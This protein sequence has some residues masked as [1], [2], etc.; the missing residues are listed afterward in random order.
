[1]A[2]EFR[3]LFDG[4]LPSLGYGIVDWIEANLRHP[5]IPGH[6]LI[7]LTPEQTNFIIL[8]YALHPR[9]GR[10]LIRRATH[11]ASKGCGKAWESAGLAYATLCGP[12]L[13]DGWD[14]NGQPVGRPRIN[15][16]IFI[17]APS[18]DAT[19]NVYSQIVGI[20]EVSDELV[21]EN[22]LH[23]GQLK[24][25]DDAN[26]LIQPVAVS[27]GAREGA[28][29]HLVL[30]DETQHF[31]L[32]RHHNVAAT[33]ARNVAKSGGLVVAT[34]NAYQIGQGSLAEDEAKVAED[35]DT[36]GVLYI[37]EAPD[38]V[39]YDPKDPE[40]RDQLLRDLRIC[41]GGALIENG[42]WI[43]V[44]RIMEDIVDDAKLTPNEAKRFFLNYPTVGEHSLANMAAWFG[45]GDDTL[46]LEDGDEV[47]L[48][49]DGSRN[50]DSTALVAI[51]LSDLALFLV[52]IWQ[53]PEDLD[54]EEEWEVDR[55]EV[56][57]KIV[58]TFDDL[59]VV[60]MFADPPLFTEMLDALVVKLGKDKVVR[61]WTSTQARSYSR[62][63]DLF[64][65]S[66]LNGMPHEDNKTLTEHV[67]NA[68]AQVMGTKFKK[69]V[70]RSDDEKIDVAVA[71][72][73]ARAALQSYLLDKADRAKKKRKGRILGAV[74]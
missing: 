5:D 60:R 20:G 42:G 19:Q 54:E 16:R 44:L 8:T 37:S 47:A 11:Q 68:Q 34:T 24:T 67:G 29:S 38:E 73:L 63:I 71:A 74:R 31:T 51:R 23:V 18:E 28:L 61:F 55:D 27:V 43:D 50:N 70:K 58:A 39:D 52:E 48:G 36:R 66:V 33:M 25:K 46:T 35:P 12:T 57:R 32:P 41:Y 13:F 69:L 49:F 30:L 59:N 4:H 2:D 7:K 17:A 9:T 1:M 45:N 40:N 62:A 14:A 15:S 65:E 64:R 56:K 10:M 26:G 6:P 22:G 53:R 72:V 3:P 21:R